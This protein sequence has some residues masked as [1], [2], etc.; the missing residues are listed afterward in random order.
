MAQTIVPTP[1]AST[2]VL[3]LQDITAV[4][5]PGPQ[6]IQ[7][8]Q[9]VQ[10][11]VGP[12]G[13]PLN[14]KGTVANAASLPTTGMAV[15]DVWITSDTGHAHSWNGTGWIDAGPFVGPQGAQ[16][17]QGV[18]G[19]PGNAATI[20]PGSTTTAAPGTP[21]NVVNTGDA[22]AAVFQFT[23]PQGIQGPQGTQGVQGVQGAQG[24]VGPQGAVGPPG[25]P[26]NMKGTV[27]TAANLPPTGNVTGDLYMAVD[28]GHAWVWGGTSWIDAGPFQGPQGIQGVNAYTAT[29]QSF[30]IP[31]IGASVSV[32][33]QDSTSF[34]VGEMVYVANAAGA[35]ISGAL[36][37]TGKVAGQLTLTNPPAAQPVV[38]IADNTQAG[39]VNILS[40]KSSDFIGGDNACHTLLTALVGFIIPTGTV[41]D[42]AGAAAPTG[43]LLCDGASY[44]Q[45]TY[46]ALYTALGGASS[47]WGV[48]GANFSVPDLRGRVSV[49]VG[50]GAS[51]TA[52]ALAAIGGEETHTLSVA[53]LASHAHVH[54][55]HTHSDAGHNHSQNAHSHSDSG[56]NHSQNPHNHGDSGHGHSASSSDSGHV[57]GYLNPT[58]GQGAQPGSG[59]YSCVG[60]TN[61]ATGY[62]NIS[63]SVATGYANIAS[64][65]ASNNTAYASITATTATNNTAY[66]S[67][68]TVTSTEQNAGSSAAHNTMPPYACLNKIIKI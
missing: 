53:E 20:V 55:S 36:Q 6:G 63:T 8:V 29:T 64:T 43:F 58:G 2:V 37:V 45:S 27:A 51:L 1:Q 28:T 33:V 68:S 30:T 61:T 5:P 14:M 44:P 48:S 60:S 23:I 25:P 3:S 4:G 50:T 49:G 7:G 13:P 34:T 21:A 15:S 10:G 57:H 65:T 42:F 12:P 54:N 59:Q 67:I 39:L 16:G 62:A 40:G 22:H 46:P 31:A 18:Q 47:P 66:A 26:L 52:R 11:Q 56:H 41:L 38:P 17:V 9:G 24:I 32:N 35:N 19:V